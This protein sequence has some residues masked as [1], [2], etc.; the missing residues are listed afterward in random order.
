MLIEPLRDV[1]SN[2]NGIV[3]TP[4]SKSQDDEMRHRNLIKTPQL[5]C[6]RS[7]IARSGRECRRIDYTNCKSYLKGLEC[8]RKL[9][10]QLRPFSPALPALDQGLSLEG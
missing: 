7:K 1:T 9:P 3:F 2:G 5:Q 4:K 10:K 8:K 6:Y